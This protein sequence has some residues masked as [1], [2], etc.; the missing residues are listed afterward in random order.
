[1][2]LGRK[3]TPDRTK[4]RTPEDNT[5]PDPPPPD[6]RNPS[7]DVFFTLGGQTTSNDRS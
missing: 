4:Q 6:F 1:V 7:V 5:T 2:P 3:Y